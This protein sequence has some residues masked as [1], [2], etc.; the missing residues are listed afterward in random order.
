MADFN[1]D[2]AEYSIKAVAQ[3]TGLSVE[4][5]RAW[6]RRYGVIE[7]RR[8][9]SGHRIYSTRDVSRLRRLRETTACGHPISKIA[10]LS[11][12]ELRNLKG[13]RD[14]A[15]P[16]GGAP[17][18]LVRRIMRAVEQ[19]LPTECDQSIALAFAL[20]PPAQ[21]IREVLA[22]ALHEAGSR[23]H[24]GEFGIGQERILSC[25]SRRHLTSLLNTYNGI[26]R[27]PTVVFATLSGERHEL[28]LLMSAA[29]A[30][31][32]HL[33]VDYLGS[34]VPAEVVGDHAL[35]VQ[36]AAVA[37]SLVMS[38]DVRRTLRQLGALREHLSK[39]VDIW[40]GGT[41]ASNIEPHRLPTGIVTLTGNRDFEQRVTLLAAIGR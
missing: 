37:I 2:G 11:D 14:S 18:M 41:G 35:R 16:V 6:E 13:D 10:H 8:G 34:D 3:A 9:V 39:D 12:D 24:S 26:A 22:P 29:L 19:Y 33:R 27:G 31:G 17:Q 36:A 15:D 28:G 30:A 40:V 38:D 5:L 21:V 4:T 23:W 1:D 7:P 25:A 20:L 32:H